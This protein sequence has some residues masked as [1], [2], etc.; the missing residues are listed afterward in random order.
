MTICAMAYGLVSTIHCCTAQFTQ[1]LQ[2]SKQRILDQRELV[3]QCNEELTCLCA[4]TRNPMAPL[5][6]FLPNKGRINCVIPTDDRALV[7]PRF[8]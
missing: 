5:T 6:G 7:V 2:E 3:A 4:G 1:Q 8:V